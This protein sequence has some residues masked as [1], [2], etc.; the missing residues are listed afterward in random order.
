M[1]EKLNQ[2]RKPCQGGKTGGD[3]G[4]GMHKDTWERRSQIGEEGK[5]IQPS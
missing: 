3:A 2:L 5:D 4:Q 1:C